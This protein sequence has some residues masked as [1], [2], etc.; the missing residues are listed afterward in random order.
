L[1]V[2]PPT[3]AQNAKM[4]HP[5][6][7]FGGEKPGAGILRWESPALPETPLPQDDHGDGIVMARLKSCPSQDHRVGDT[8]VC[9]RSCGTQGPST[10][11]RFGRDDR[12]VSLFGDG[13][14]RSLEVAL[15]VS[16]PTF[17]QNAKMG[18]PSVWFGWERTWCRDPSLGVSGFAGDSAASG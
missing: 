2:S 18:H 14:F 8:L 16:P 11:L 5:S 12:V 7:W 1:V 13:S 9:G 15:A 17:A 10:A 4:G 6:V 3:F